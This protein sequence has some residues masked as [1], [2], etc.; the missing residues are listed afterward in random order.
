MPI[1]VQQLYYPR[2]W[3]L[4]QPF[5]TVKADVFNLN[6]LPSSLLTAKGTPKSENSEDS[7]RSGLAVGHGKGSKK[8]SNMA[9]RDLFPCTKPSCYICHMLDT[10]K[11]YYL[12]LVHEADEHADKSLMHRVKTAWDEIKGGL[13]NMP[14]DQKAKIFACLLGGRLKGQRF[15]TNRRTPSLR[16]FV[17]TSFVSR[18]LDFLQMGQE[19]MKLA[20]CF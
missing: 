3:E 16:R 10:K 14:D 18:N 12:H 4:A 7:K 8:K 9:A 2:P 5:A 19:C 11:A 17:T 1:R 6:Q 15:T 20:S 13:K